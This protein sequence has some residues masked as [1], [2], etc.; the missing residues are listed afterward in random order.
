VFGP[1][2]SLS[3]RAYRVVRE[4]ISIPVS[5]GVDLAATVFRPDDDGQFPVIL[6]VH[7]YDG[8]MQST[9]SM[10]QALQGANAQ[11]EAGDPRFYAR[12]GYVHVI[13]NARGTGGSGGTYQHYGPRDVDDVVEVIAWLAR[14]RWSTGRVGMFGMSYFSVAAK[15]VAARNP[16]AL[17]AVFAPYGYTDFYRDKFF[18]GGI[19]ARSFVTSW[20]SHLAGV[21]VEGWSRRNLGEDEFGRRLEELRADS[22]IMAV[23]QLA[24]AIAAPDEGPNPLIVD[25]LMNPL[26]GPYWAERNPD[27]SAVQVPI[28]LGGCWGMY[29]LHLPGEFRAWERITAPKKLFVGPPIYVDRPVYQYAQESLRWF[30]HWLKDNDTG[31]LDEAPIQLFLPG[32]DGEWIEAEQWPLPQTRWQSFYLHRDGLLSEHEHWPHEGATS[33]EDNTFNKRGAITFTTPPLVERTT[34]L[35]H[36]TLTLHAATTDDEL[37]VFASMWLVDGDGSRSMLT[38]VWLRGSMRTVNRELSKPWLVHH[39][40]T[41]RKPLEPD[42]IHELELN[43]A[44]TAIVLHPGQRLELQISSSDEDDAGTFMDLI[45]QGHLLRQSPSWISVYHDEDHPSTLRLP[46]IEGNR[47]GTYLSGG[48]PARPG[49]GPARS[50]TNEW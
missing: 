35:G 33:Y 5:G 32:S 9:P 19:L 50:S 36:A 31:Y 27:L 12:R 42:T 28:V 10:P 8:A 15:Q 14:Q 41:D 3:P 40:F 34:I 17:K 24:A 7:A 39:D 44:P 25:V 45:S 6:G 4:R 46:V 1:G 47:I 37:L 26:D 16:E 13:V 49:A 48:V 11:A 20:S 23:A 30:D 43:I 18:H 21:R 29:G 38:R 22:D 2:W